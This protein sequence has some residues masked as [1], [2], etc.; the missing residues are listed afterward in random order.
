MKPL[1][2]FPE[3]IAIG[4]VFSRLIG[5]FISFPIFNSQ[6]VPLN[7]RIMLIIS[8]SFFIFHFSNVNIP[9]VSDI[10]LV[11]LFMLVLKE[12]LI[13][14]LLGVIT[15]IFIA[16]FSYAAELIGYFMGLTIA[17]IFDPT[18][19]QVS[20]L[21]RFYIFLFYLLF[22]I[23]GA[24]QYLIVGL[25]KSFEVVPLFELKI[26]SGIFEYILLKSSLIFLLA[27]K[28]AFPFVIVLLMLNVA[29]ALVNRLI[30]QV[31]VFIVG[32]P[33]QIFVGLLALSIGASGSILF[34]SYVMKLFT[35][36]YLKAVMNI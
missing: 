3:A 7:V 31:N 12:L 16:I 36:I 13:G 1:I 32:L 9:N 26:D 34:A 28:M 22:L 27:L 17:N 8:L 2:T 6:V 18:F 21:D 10:N 30:P 33:M 14:I 29:L 23:T 5:F 4:L 20:I 15:H 11:F 19:G 25:V 24:Y 35:K